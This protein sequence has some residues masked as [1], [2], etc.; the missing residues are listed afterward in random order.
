MSEYLATGVLLRP[1]GVH[2]NIN[3]RLFSDQFEHLLKI[4]EVILKKGDQQRVETI[5]SVKGYNEGALIK[6]VGI[7]RREEVEKLTGWEVWILRSQAPALEK[8]EFYVAD[9]HQCNLIFDSKVVAQVVSTIDGPQSLLLEVKSTADQK[10]YLI[11]FMA[12]FIG[13]VNIEKRELELLAPQLLQ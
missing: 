7:E 8:G 11:P 5:A 13:K 12:Q 3:I 2:G 4:K 9:L 10:N 6:F 1:H